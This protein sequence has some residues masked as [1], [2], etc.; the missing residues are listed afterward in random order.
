MSNT[1]FPAYPLAITGKVPHAIPPRQ[2]AAGDLFW[3]S[4]PAGVRLIYSVEGNLLRYV[5]LHSGDRDQTTVE[6]LEKELLFPGPH[7]SPMHEYGDNHSPRRSLF[8]GNSQEL[9][10]C[11]VGLCAEKQAHA[12]TQL[13]LCNE[14]RYRDRDRA[15]AE[16]PQPVSG[17][18]L[19]PQTDGVI[20]GSPKPNTD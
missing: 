14:A 15:E 5:R 20:A 10:G 9:L 18:E 17:E 6:G 16:I 2:W 1:S 8:I 12:E 11:Y 3:R 19:Q 7:C 4:D 13:R